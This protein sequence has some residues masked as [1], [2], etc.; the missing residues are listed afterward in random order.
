MSAIPRVTDASEKATARIGLATALVV[1]CNRGIRMWGVAPRVSAVVRRWQSRRKARYRGTT[2]TVHEISRPF[3]RWVFVS[4]AH[5]DRPWM[6]RLRAHLKPLERSCGAGIFT[7]AQIDTGGDWDEQIK[8]QLSDA[9]AAVLLI[10]ADFLAS[11]YISD[12]EFPALL[13]GAKEE[14]GDL[15]VFP[16]FVG[17][18][19]YDEVTF[20][21]TFEGRR[22][23]RSLSSV[24]GA[25]DPAK[26]LVC[27]TA[28]QQEETLANVA[29]KIAAWFRELDHAPVGPKPELPRTTHHVDVSRMPRSANFFKGRDDD[30]QALDKCLEDKNTA[31]CTIV[32]QGGEGKSALVSHWL[33]QLEWQGWKGSRAFAWSF[34]SQGTR[35]VS[36]SADDFIF[37]ALKFFGQ[38]PPHEGPPEAKGKLLAGLVKLE[39]TILILDGLEPLQDSNGIIEDQAVA[40]LVTTLTEAPSANGLCVI[41]TRQ[42]VTDRKA[43]ED[44][45]T[46]PGERTNADPEQP[47]LKVELIE[48]KPLSNQ[49]GARL[50]RMLG[51]PG[52]HRVLGYL[53]SEV[54]GHPLSL[55]LMGTYIRDVGVACA[56]GVDDHLPSI[57]TFMPPHVCLRIMAYERYFDSQ[58][59]RDVL[60]IL[61]LFDRPATAGEIAALKAKRIA[62]LTDRIAKISDEGEWQ[63]ILKRLQRAGLI[64]EPTMENPGGIDAHPLIREYFAERL[65][66]DHVAAWKTGHERLYTFLS[67]PNE[68]SQLPETLRE[69]T[70]FYQAMQHAVWAGCLEEALKKVYWP[71][72]QRG[73]KGY[74]HRQLGAFQSELNMLRA[75]FT[76]PWD[77]LREGLSP[78]WRAHVLGIA[79]SRL[80]ALGRLN[81][82][83][84][85]LR[86][87][88]ELHRDEGHILYAGIRARHLCELHMEMGQLPEAVKFGKASVDFAEGLRAGEASKAYSDAQMEQVE[89]S[90]VKYQRLVAHTVCGAAQHQRGNMDDAGRSFARACQCTER[91]PPWGTV[92]S[93]FSLWGFRYCEYLIDAIRNASN[94]TIRDKLLS[95]LKKQV[96][97]MRSMSREDIQEYVPEGDLGLLGPSLVDLVEIRADF[98]T[99]SSQASD[100]LIERAKKVAEELR[101]GKRRDFIPLGILNFVQLVRTYVQQSRRS[102]DDRLAYKWLERAKRE[103]KD[104]AAI[105]EDG[106]MGLYQVDC[107]IELAWLCHLE[108][109]D[110]SAITHY[111][112][113]AKE[114]ENLHYGCRKLDLEKLGKEVQNR[115]RTNRK[116]K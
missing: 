28:C 53:S 9:N 3:Q 66:R 75:C 39:K 114:I 23:R 63:S 10:S 47:K 15:N 83:I 19:C 86:R 62:G 102:G 34:Y 45:V 72:I 46:D 2:V 36:A 91:K 31:V 89:P 22:E 33:R 54:N 110:G 108:I 74:S 40:A 7:D 20:E 84:A 69:M 30:L 11:K 38:Q 71:K 78:F 14:R 27:Q 50:L 81:E 90:S 13:A 76:R 8:Q 32:A 55:L 77:E 5:R 65:R 80:R 101:K 41:T 16:V 25:N 103:L 52:S 97:A 113:A 96:G 49:D 87:S 68:D 1:R 29:R 93:L 44:K 18:S 70:R 4:Y 58:P 56:T 12:Y 109:E 94:V 99:S 21:Y 51:V 112:N 92:T 105:A 57:D 48:L 82:A 104:A 61:G 107:L 95:D 59:H 35:E 42:P 100:D 43:V 64:N 73:Q 24:M 106:G 60:R 115:K 37:E 85:P 88:M 98:L 67:A 79:G 6:E 116:R 111:E 26:P 17:P